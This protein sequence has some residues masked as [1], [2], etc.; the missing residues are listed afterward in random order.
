[1]EDLNAMKVI[2]LNQIIKNAQ[3]IIQDGGEMR[4]VWNALYVEQDL[5]KPYVHHTETKS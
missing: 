4:E 3:L 2:R 1:M 5:A